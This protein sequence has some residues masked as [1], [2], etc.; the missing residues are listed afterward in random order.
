MKQACRC[1]GM[2]P[3]CRFCSGSGSV[4]IPDMMPEITKFHCPECGKKFNS[5]S[6]RNEHRRVKHNVSF[7]SD[8]TQKGISWEPA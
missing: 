7:R 3:N 2:N 4:E 5:A 1:N 8:I 6:G